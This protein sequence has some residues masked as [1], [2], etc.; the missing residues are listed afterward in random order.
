MAARLSSIGLLDYRKWDE[1]RLTQTGEQ[2]A[3][4]ISWRH[5]IIEQYLVEKLD[6]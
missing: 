3:R 1:V 2:T 6:S 5:E 4:M